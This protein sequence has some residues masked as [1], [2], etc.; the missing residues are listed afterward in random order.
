[1]NV[2][3]QTQDQEVLIFSVGSKIKLSHYCEIRGSLLPCTAYSSNLKMEVVPPCET[4][5]NCYRTIRRPVLEDS[6]PHSL[7]FFSISSP[8]LFLK[9][10]TCS[11]L[12]FIPFW[13]F[14][15]FILTLFHS[16]FFLL[17]SFISLLSS[18][19]FF[20]FCFCIYS[21]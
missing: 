2:F 1:M 7:I 3:V 21:F 6:T 11:F 9:F 18:I 13:F 15:L 20:N 10:I 4:S 17:S 14:L 19:C 16:L 8:I 5:V 12:S